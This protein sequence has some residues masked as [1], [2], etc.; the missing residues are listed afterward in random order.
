[1]YTFLREFVLGTNQTGYFDPDASSVVGGVHTE[2]LK[3]ILT[4]SAV[5]TGIGTTQ[6]T[7]TWPESKWNAW[8][9]YMA[10]RTAAD[11]PMV[12]E[13]GNE[14]RGEARRLGLPSIFTICLS[15]FGILAL[16]Q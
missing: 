5:Y 13:T 16:M 6:G 9:S 4:G 7:Y 1:M 14:V 11:V 10:T 3:G 2:Y 15:T 8:N 12:T